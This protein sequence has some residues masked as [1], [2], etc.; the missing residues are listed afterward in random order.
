MPMKPCGHTMGTPEM[1]P[2][3]AVNFFA[4]LGYEAIEFLCLGDYRCAVNPEAP[5]SNHRE[6]AERIRDRGLELACLTPYATDLNA[7]DAEKYQQ[8]KELLKR[9]IEI[10]SRMGFPFVRVYGGRIVEPD[11]RAASVERL[12]AALRECAREAQA[13]SVVL[14]VENHYNTLTVTAAETM[15]IIQAVDHPAVCILYDQCNITQMGGEEFPQAITLQRERIAHVHVKDIEFKGKGPQGQTK[16]VSH[17]D[18]SER[19]VRSRVIGQGVLPWPKI[20]QNLHD[21]G[22][23][24][25]L[26][27]EYSRKWYPEDLPIPEIGLKQSLDHLRACL[28]GLS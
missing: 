22:Y 28:G 13:G 3:E 4:D 21:I 19:A 11:Q 12:A 26:S 10:A 23:R 8:Q 15:E 18:P 16:D 1:S 2:A 20:I 6:L 9:S 5:A 24:G 14:A 7:Q 27:V 25:Y 17:I